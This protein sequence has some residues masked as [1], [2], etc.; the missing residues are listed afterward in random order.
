VVEIAPPRPR[1]PTE[2]E[3]AAYIQ[4]LRALI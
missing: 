4:R 3:I 1:D 2:P